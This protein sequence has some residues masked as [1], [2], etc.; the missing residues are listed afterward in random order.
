[1][2]KPDEFLWIRLGDAAEY[3]N[4]GHDLAA[5]TSLLLDVGVRKIWRSS[6]KLGVEAEGFTGYNYIS[7]YWGDRDA[8]GIRPITT[9]ELNQI[10]K[11]L[12]QP[13]KYPFI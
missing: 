3:E 5:L 4:Y 12:A 11:W 7:L 6:R 9:R 10:N 13:E 8:A 1:M 2:P